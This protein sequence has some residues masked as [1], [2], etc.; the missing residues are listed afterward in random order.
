MPDGFFFFFLSLRMNKCL[1]R[2]NDRHFWNPG[3]F[4]YAMIPRR[5]PNSKVFFFFHR[6]IYSLWCEH[7]QSHSHIAT[8]ACALE[9]YTFPTGSV[10]LRKGRRQVLAILHLSVLGMQNLWS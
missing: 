6:H 7:A 1:E 3:V 9:H 8:V 10:A 5:H 2:V 4:S